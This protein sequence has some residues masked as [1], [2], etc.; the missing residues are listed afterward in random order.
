[1]IRRLALVACV[2]VPLYLGCSAAGDENG[3]TED[4][5]S[6]AEAL[7]VGAHGKTF[8]L[9]S[10][11]NVN[12]LIG[13]NDQGKGFT[14]IYGSRTRFRAAPLDKFA[15]TDPCREPAAKYNGYIAVNDTV[16]FNAALTAM[17][18]PTI[19][20]VAVCKARVHVDKLNVIT[21]FEPIP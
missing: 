7:S 14:G 12:Q 8:Y 13:L 20:P 15:P 2:A 11:D 1:M 3:A 10:F 4:V 21:S 5:G 19:G 16:G 18:P 9:T 17:V 6:T